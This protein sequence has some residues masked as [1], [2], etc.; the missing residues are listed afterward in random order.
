M[1]NVVVEVKKLRSDAIIPTKGS[2][3]AAGSDLYAIETVEI[4]PGKRALISTGLS[5]AVPNGLYIR[6]AP[7]SGL[8]VKQGVDVLAG[9]VD[10]D[11]RGEIKVAII[12]LGQERFIVKPGDR[13]AQMIIE[14]IK[15]P[16]FSEVNELS[17]TDRSA[18]GFGSTGV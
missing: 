5:M 6:I 18:N 15:L 2:E 8:A 11:Y 4:L 7:R 3:Y 1:N 9:V 10:S 17:D 12:N 14:Q 13:I 16:T